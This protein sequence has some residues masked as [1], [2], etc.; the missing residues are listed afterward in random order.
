MDLDLEE[1]LEVLILLEHLRVLEED[2]FSD[3]QLPKDHSQD[4]IRTN[5]QTQR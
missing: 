5:R 1:V 3:A 4:P 2:S